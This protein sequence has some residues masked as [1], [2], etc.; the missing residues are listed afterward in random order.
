MH[1]NGHGKSASTL[2]REAEQTRS[3]IS[4]TLEELRDRMTPGQVVDQFVDYARETGGADF[5]RTL[6]NQV[7]A[8]PL[9][10]TLIGAGIAWLMFSGGRSGAHSVPPAHPGTQP[11]GGGMVGTGGSMHSST[12]SPS[13]S[14]SDSASSVGQT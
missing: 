12:G 10:V 8:N 2:E 4:A 5:M 14:W 11:Y 9:P 7:R 13:G 1:N 3:N 6:G